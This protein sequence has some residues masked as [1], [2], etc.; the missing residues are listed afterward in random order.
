[1]TQI[2]LWLVF[3]CLTPFPVFSQRLREKERESRILE[4][5]R[6]FMQG[7]L[8]G[9]RKLLDE[10]AK[11]FPADAGLD[12]LQGIIEV[13]EGNYAAAERSF[14]R[15]VTRDRNFTGAYLNLGRL[16]QEHSAGD[17]QALTKALDVYRRALLYDAANPEANYQSAA[18][19]MRKGAYRSSL[20]HLARLPAKLQERAQALSVS[21][22]DYAGLGLI[23]RANETADRLIA[24]P[25]F[26]ESDVIAIMPALTGAG[27]DDLSVE[28]LEGLLKRRTLSSDMRRRLGLAYERTGKLA[29]ARAALE[30]SVSGDRPVAALLADLARVARKQQ[31]YQ[32]ALGYLAHARDLEPNDAGLHYF[33]GLVCL[34]LRLVAAARSAFDKAVKIE[35]ENPSYNY[36]MGATSTFRHDP[37]EAIPYFEKY[38]RLK[39]HDARGKLALG[40][41]L[42][43]AKQYD[44]AVRALMEAVKASDT[45]TAAHYYLGAVARRSGKLDEAV[46]E[47]RQALKADPEYADALAELGQCYLMR[48]EYE[49][50]GELLR[51]AL[52]IA[53]D[54]Y[55]ANFNLLTLYARTKDEREAAQ[56]AQFEEVKKLREETSREILRMIEI[57]P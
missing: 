10:A 40:A 37:A 27:R 45:A 22:A 29:E 8:A 23:E 49:S 48:R 31:D 36:A 16:Y 54:H 18:L 55:A 44:A 13:Q 32:G 12:N 51:R 19:L 56:S 39:P 42:M 46:L 26:S 20:D 15:A 24:H 38:V 1:M 50:A 14:R 17:P 41:A 57:H 3:L 28:L 21:C 47:L 7:D 33:F 4:I 25:D 52:K 6:L 11:R 2:I 34:D 53:P 30:Q 35:P 5:Q 9:A 43:G